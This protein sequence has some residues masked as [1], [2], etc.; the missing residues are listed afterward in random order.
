MVQ[1]PC[2]RH[3]NV[4]DGHCTGCF[5]TI[6]EITQWRNMDEKEKEEVC[7]KICSRRSSMQALRNK[8]ISDDDEN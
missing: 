4:R 8:G 6:E 2:T 1:S 5:R 3:C 7:S